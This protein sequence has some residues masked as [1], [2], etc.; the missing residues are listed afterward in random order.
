MIFQMSVCI[1]LAEY[2]GNSEDNR[3]GKGKMAT[4]ATILNLNHTTAYTFLIKRTMLQSYPDEVIGHR[5]E[6]NLRKFSD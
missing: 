3:W 2:C 1:E 6:S 5:N 4:K